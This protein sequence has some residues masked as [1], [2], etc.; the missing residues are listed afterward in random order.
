[1]SDLPNGAESVDD[2]ALFADVTGREAAPVV[3][4]PAPVAKEP[5]TTT[6]PNP[7]PEPAIPPARLREEAEAR[8]KA[9][10]ELD[11]LRGRLAAM[12]EQKKPAEQPK[13]PDFWE[14]PNAF[15]QNSLT[16]MQEQFQQQVQEMREHF[17]KQTA[18]A[19]HGAEVVKA[20]EDAVEEALRQLPPDQQARM[21]AARGKDL[22]PYGE[23]VRWNKQRMAMQEVG[24]DPAAY[25][26][27]ILEESLKD[28]E[29]LK[30]ALE[31]A[32][33]TATATG[34]TITR[35]P[36]AS[37]PSLSKVGAV[38]LPEGQ[39]EASDSELF[40]SITKRRRG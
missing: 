14:D 11:E 23:M 21:R 39:D 7:A 15:V 27:R 10:R 29:F 6:E 32:R 37:I 34:N 20:A 18:I 8:R 28:P 26:S 17:S 1:M 16:P 4:E 19:Q 13:A 2:T 31:A 38:A 12:Q 35:P 25:K 22:D 40:A 3:V 36:V 24:P 30:R 9:E 33:G 5:A